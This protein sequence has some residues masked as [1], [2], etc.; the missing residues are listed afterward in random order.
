MN[1]KYLFNFLYI[2][3]VLVGVVF[4]MYITEHFF[5]LGNLIFKINPSEC[6]GVSATNCP[7]DLPLLAYLPFSALF[8]VIMW[9]SY[10]LFFGLKFDK[11]IKHRFFIL[12]FLFSIFFWMLVIYSGNQERYDIVFNT[13]T[14]VKTNTNLVNYVNY[15]PGKIMAMT[16]P[17]FGIFIEKKYESEGNQSGSILAHERIHWLQYQELGLWKFYVN[18]FAGYI[19]YGRFNAP[20]EIDARARSFQ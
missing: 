16:I 18:Y 20:M 12:M 15:L 2:T 7:G 14:G 9:A 8:V 4:L 11:K 6:I 17:P 5:H 1:R 19:K 3:F 10:Y 13:S